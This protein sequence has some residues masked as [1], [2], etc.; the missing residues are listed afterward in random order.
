MIYNWIAILFFSSSLTYG[1]S[2]WTGSSDAGG[3]CKTW[4][5]RSAT[6][7]RSMRRSRR[8][9]FLEGFGLGN[10][11]WAWG[12]GINPSSGLKTDFFPLK[13][14]KDWYWIPHSVQVIS[15]LLWNTRWLAQALTQERQNT[16]PQGSSARFFFVVGTRQIGHVPLFF[17]YGL[18]SKFVGR[19][20]SLSAIVSGAD[21]RTEKD[22]CTLDMKMLIDEAFYKML[23]LKYLWKASNMEQ[24]ECYGE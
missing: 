21:I 4:R 2:S 23:N 1:V 13:V 17:L 15:G 11:T 24:I 6:W 12:T 5:R 20:S 7:T 8:R 22:T 9:A 16:W 19:H 10:R 3:F 14:Q 18:F